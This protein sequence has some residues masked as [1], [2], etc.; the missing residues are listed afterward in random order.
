MNIFLISNMYPSDIHPSYGIFVKNFEDALIKEGHS[1]QKTVIKGRGENAFEKVSKYLLFFFDVWR[2][3]LFA[4]YDLIYIHY[5]SHSILPLVPFR[6]FIKRP[7]I[8][9]AHGDDILPSSLSSKVIFK[10]TYKFITRSIMMVVPSPF[11]KKV[12]FKAYQHPNIF[13]SPSG[14]VDVN[15]FY[16]DPN[17]PSNENL[18][19][20]YVS[21]ID[22]GKGWDVFLQALHKLKEKDPTI[23]FEGILVNT[24]A[25]VP[26]MR[27]MIQ[28]LELDQSIQYL[29]LKP[30]DRL[31]KIYRSFDLLV[32]PTLLQESLGLVGLEAM[33]CGIPVVGSRIGGL[34]DYIIDNENGYLFIPGDIQGLYTKLISYAKLPDTAKQ[35]MK[36]NA[37]KKAQEYEMRKISL[38]LINKLKSIA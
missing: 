24:G 5:A 3:L 33:A 31:P 18:R 26:R 20:G 2:R 35:K 1:I 27:K 28:A 12:A 7:I 32:F 16:P 23:S 13:V 10:L 15:I 29:G 38:E 37:Y 8:I 22:H 19:I 34:Q 6:V 30:Q 25:D 21:R 14:G 36:T 4:K 11:F 17:Q 9:N